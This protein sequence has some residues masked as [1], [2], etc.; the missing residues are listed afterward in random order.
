MES[1][2]FFDGNIFYCFYKGSRGIYGLGLNL[3]F[4]NSFQRRSWCSFNV[5]LK[6]LGP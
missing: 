4:D 5:L 2:K 6:I 3:F 1:C